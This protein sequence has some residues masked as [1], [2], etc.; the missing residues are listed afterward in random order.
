MPVLRIGIIAALA[1]GTLWGVLSIHWYPAEEVLTMWV[2]GSPQEAELYRKVAAEYR[3]QHPEVRLRL[4]VVPG[5]SV[6]QKLLTGM[7]AGHAPDICVMHWRQMSQVASTGQLLPLDDLVRRDQID[8]DDYYPVGLQAYT[9]HGTLYG[10]P[11]K[12]STITCFYNKN[13][14]DRYGV[15]YPTDDWTLDDLLVPRPRP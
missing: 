15:S 6:V 3:Q 4:E 13:L 5:R 14:F 10:I 8:T 1:A 7:D 12:G 2:Y 9:Y 11:V